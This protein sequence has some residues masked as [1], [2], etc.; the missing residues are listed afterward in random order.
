[1]ILYIKKS[2]KSMKSMKKPVLR[3]PVPG[4]IIKFRYKAKWDYALLLTGNRYIPLTTQMFKQYA[5]TQAIEIVWKNKT[6]MA[7]K[8]SIVPVTVPL[9]Y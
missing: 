9:L 2:M 7:R 3:Q 8:W 4:D 1:M 5:G 6:P